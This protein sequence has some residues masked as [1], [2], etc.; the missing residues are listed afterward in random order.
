MYISVAAT[1][2]P[3]RGPFR[4]DKKE[5]KRE[6]IFS[7]DEKKN[8]RSRNGFTMPNILLYYSIIIVIIISLRFRAYRRRSSVNCCGLRV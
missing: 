3:A 6:S 7:I 8:E 5:V 4:G 1:V 2:E